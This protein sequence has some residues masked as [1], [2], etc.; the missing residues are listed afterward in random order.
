[1]FSAI[2]HEQTNSGRSGMSER[3]QKLP[4][5]SQQIASLFD[6]LVGTAEQRNWH[7]KTQRLGSLEV[8]DEFNFRRLLHRQVSG[9]LAFQ[10]SPGIEP[11]LIVCVGKAAAV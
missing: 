5:A 11:E 4:Y 2:P 9:F 10:Q 1:M 8:D 6:H 7:R 3:C